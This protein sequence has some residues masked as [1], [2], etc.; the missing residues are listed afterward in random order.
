F[1]WTGD[2]DR[3]FGKDQPGGWAYN[4]L[5]YLEENII[6]DLGKGLT[7]IDK[8]QALLQAM[9]MPV[10]AYLCPTRRSDLTKFA[11]SPPNGIRNAIDLPTPPN[12]ARSGLLRQCGRSGGSTVQ[13]ISRPGTKFAEWWQ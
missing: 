12:V 8:E 7:G 9:Q 2:P 6:H 10:A 4:I 3:G 13:G 11:F 1:C 5:P